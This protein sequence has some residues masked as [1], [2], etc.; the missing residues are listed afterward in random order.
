MLAKIAGNFKPIEGQRM[1][2]SLL[3]SIRQTRCRGHRPVNLGKGQ[4]NVE[5]HRADSKCLV[6]F[7]ILCGRYVVEYDATSAFEA[8]MK[9][10]FLCKCV[11]ALETARWPLGQ[12]CQSEP[13][14]K[15]R[16]P[17]FSLRYP[18]RSKG[19]SFRC[20]SLEDVSSA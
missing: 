5:T 15:N 6:P 2:C 16:P 1:P 20:Y 18:A 14:T 11:N 19:S 9:H 4:R 17:L 13:Q 10:G 7:Y 3:Y 8:R 12:I